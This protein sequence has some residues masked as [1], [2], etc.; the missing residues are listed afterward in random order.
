[1]KYIKKKKKTWGEG[2][3]M[4]GLSEMFKVTAFLQ[5]QDLTN[6]IFL[7]FFCKLSKVSL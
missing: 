5:R 3:E 1:M 7:I 6:L 4:K 2:N